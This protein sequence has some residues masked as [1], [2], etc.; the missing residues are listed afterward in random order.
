MGFTI[1]GGAS[2]KVEDQVVCLEGV[3][4]EGPYVHFSSQSHHLGISQVLEH[5][6]SK[7]HQ[8]NGKKV[9]KCRV[10]F[11]LQHKMI[12]VTSNLVLIQGTTKS[13]IFLNTPTLIHKGY[14]VTLLPE[15]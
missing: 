2:I 12:K 3:Y 1:P 11:T 6:S 10:D 4:Q 7:H 8:R 13:E 15:G 14:K 9:A 5:P